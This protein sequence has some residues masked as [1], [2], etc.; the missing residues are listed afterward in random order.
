MSRNYVEV[1]FRHR[2]LILAPVLVALIAGTAFALLQ[3]RQYQATASIWADT[4]VTAESTIGTEAG[5][6]PPS[7]GQAALFSE[8]LATRGFALDVLEDSPGGRTL[9]GLDPLQVNRRLATLRERVTTLTPG[10]HILSVGVEGSSPES[11]VATTTVLVQRFLDEQDALVKRRSDT[12]LA[13]LKQQ[14]DVADLA[15]SQARTSVPLG[16]PDAPKVLELALQAAQQQRLD[17]Q[18]AYQRAL[19]ASATTGDQSLVY[20]QDEPSAVRLSRIKTLAFGTGGGLVAGATVSLLLLVLLM[21]RDDSIRDEDELEALL[22]LRVVGTI[23]E[24]PHGDKALASGG[25]KD[26]QLEPG[27][28]PH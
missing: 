1:F 26:R 25:L 14:V 24:F 23:D 20:V 19:A 27:P 15:V 3:P 4:P 9:A 5:S 16:T 21:A 28:S 10:P 11:A 2:V 18:Q 8:L 22:G 13:F 7:A 12:E 6:T 17:A